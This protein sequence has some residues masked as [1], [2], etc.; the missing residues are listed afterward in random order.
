MHKDYDIFNRIESTSVFV[1]HKLHLASKH[2][3]DQKKTNL[4]TIDK[5]R[6]AT[7][8]SINLQQ[9]KQFIN[10]YS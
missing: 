8:P 4:R 5:S 1:G 10:Q 2:S 3:P 7:M 6:I 9:S